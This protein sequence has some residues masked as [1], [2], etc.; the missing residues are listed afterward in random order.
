MQSFLGVDPSGETQLKDVAPYWRVALNK[1]KDEWNGEIGTFGLASGT[2]PGRAKSAGSDRITDVGVDSQLQY[3]TDAHSVT[4]NLSAIYEW[5]D[6]RAS[7]P[8]GVANLSHGHLLTTNFVVQYLYD[9]T[10][11]ADVGYFYTTGAT[12]PTLWGTR[13][14]SPRTDGWRFEVDWLPFNKSGGPWFW[15]YSNVKFDLQYTVYNTFNGART[16]FDGEGRNAPDNDTLFL[17]AWLVRGE[18]FRVPHSV[19]SVA[20][21]V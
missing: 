6:W 5:D 11:G 10:Y 16:N 17:E 18:P 3:L 13:N 19:G 20:P 2:Y 1:E 14:G 15:P 7:R 9:S 8:L 12:D 4:T 21:V